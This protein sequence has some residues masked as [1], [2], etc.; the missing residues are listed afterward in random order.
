M[1]AVK[2]IDPPEWMIRQST[3]S[4]MHAIGGY[5]NPA[6]A[7]F[8]GGCVRDELLGR[9]VHDIDIAT[10]HTPPQIISLLEKAGIKA[11]P[12]GI[13]HGTITAVSNGKSFEITTLRR[14]VET[15]GRHAV[16]AF[17]T[18]W[19]EDAQRRDF[20]F[21]TLL[22]DCEGRIYDPTGQGVDDLER[23][24]VIFVGDAQQRIREDY[25]RI[26][27]FFRFH[28][29]V[30]KGAPDDAALAACRAEAGNMGGLSRERITQEL[31]KLLSV[32]DPA[33][34]LSLM[35]ENKVLA[36]LPDGDFQANIMTRLCECQT[37]CQA[38]DLPARLFVLGGL[39]ERFFEQYCVLSNAQKKDIT[40]LSKAHES[41]DEIS[42]KMLKLLIYKYKNKIALQSL[43]IRLIE[44]GT[45]DEDLVELA[46]TWEAPTFPITGE[47]LIAE[48]VPQG[49]ELGRRL[50]ELEEQWLERILS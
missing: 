10:I 2:Q 42:E 20:T 24:S 47:D 28:A 8:V 12:T 45:F 38:F 9:P 1:K 27:R 30:G 41:F 11:I 34:T 26:L 22:A 35:F 6:S 40:S 3:E 4:V 16:I 46:A 50:K 21:N 25:L 48:G 32:A 5:D 36:D 19:A 29:Q 44:A 39:K 23:R 14:D 33:P 31:F 7:L 49:P 15:D 43:F 37:H 17:T 18:D 13:D